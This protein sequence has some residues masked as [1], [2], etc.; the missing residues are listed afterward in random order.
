MFLREEQFPPSLFF[1]CSYHWLNLQKKSLH[2]SLRPMPGHTHNHCSTVNGKKRQNPGEKKWHLYFIYKKY[3]IFYIFFSFFFFCKF[4]FCGLSFFGGRSSRKW[5]EKWNMALGLWI[6]VR[7]GRRGRLSS[8]PHCRFN[9]CYAYKIVPRLS[10]ADKL[11]CFEHWDAGSTVSTKCV[12]NLLT[13]KS[14]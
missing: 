5:A 3:I 6:I 4:Y 1:L 2:S 12:L 14:V 13:S 8:P 7:G 9:W 11:R 10:G